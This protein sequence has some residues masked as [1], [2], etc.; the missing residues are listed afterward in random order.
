[1]KKRKV[2]VMLEIKTSVPQSLL[3]NIFV[4]LGKL[5]AVSGRVDIHQVSIQAVR[6]ND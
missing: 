6:S 1:M 5:L 3:R 4:T 2:L